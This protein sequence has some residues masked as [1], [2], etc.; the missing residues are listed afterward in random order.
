MDFDF[1]H[2]TFAHILRSF[3]SSFSFLFF[4]LCEISKYD[5]RERKKKKESLE[6]RD[7]DDIMIFRGREED[8]I[9]LIGIFNIF[10]E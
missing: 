2:F 10:Y 6:R 5:L 9:V 1:F 7:L 3:L 8:K 4:F